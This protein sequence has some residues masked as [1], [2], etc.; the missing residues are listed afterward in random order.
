M[1]QKKEDDIT[2][3][4]LKNFEMNLGGEQE[5]VDYDDL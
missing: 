5:D 1:K 3:H 4:Q 2:D